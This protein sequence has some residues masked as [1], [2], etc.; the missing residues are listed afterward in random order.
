MKIKTRKKTDQYSWK[1]V[2]YKNIT[3]NYLPILDGGG[4]DQLNETFVRS[5]KDLFGRVNSICE[6]GCGPGFIGFSLL[7][8][9]LCKKLY[10]IDVNPLAIKACQK[11]IKENHLENKVTTCL[12]DALTNVPKSEKWDLVVSN[13][14]H[15]DGKYI[16]RPGEILSIDPKWHIHKNFYAKVSKHLT[17]N[18]SVLFLENGLGSTPKIFK[19][20]IAKNGLVFIKSFKCKPT[21]LQILKIYL[22]KVNLV[23]LK[24]IFFSHGRLA[25][26]T[27][28]LLLTKNPH[29][30]MW[31]KKI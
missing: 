16:N 4:Q 6:F 26:S 11:T 17:K 2:R 25:I 31:S 12:S 15:F 14:P 21:K 24:Q 23:N 27:N 9:K 8:H 22:K 5:V 28:I 1:T 3:V 10:L 19:N 18:G 30:F 13:P 29:Y 7:A 20:M